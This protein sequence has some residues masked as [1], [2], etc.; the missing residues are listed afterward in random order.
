MFSF[1]SGN[2]GVIVLVCLVGM[3]LIACSTTR[4]SEKKFGKQEGYPNFSLTSTDVTTDGG[5]GGEPPENDPG[6]EQ[7]S[8]VYGLCDLKYP[9]VGIVERSH[10]NFVVFNGQGEAYCDR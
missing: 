8:A 6:N 4:K 3:G 10:E 2:Y 1:K 7:C 9:V 5:Y